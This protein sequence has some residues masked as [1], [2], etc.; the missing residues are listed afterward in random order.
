MLSEKIYDLINDQIN[1][2]MYSA[3]LYLD[4]SGY[5]GGRGLGGFAAWYRK[6][7]EE[8]MEHAFKFYDYLHDNG[9]KVELKA[10][11]K[12]D[13]VLK[14]DKEVLQMALEHEKYVT[15]LINNIYEASATERD[16]R[17]KQ[18]LD[19][20]V[21]EQLEEEANA[22]ELISKYELYG[23]CAAGL[24]NLNKELGKRE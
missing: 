16:F 2:E 3:Y 14:D 18:F 15:S 5:F 10:I 4:F 20:F 1:K 13:K 6:Q 11:A 22:E 23:G 24:Y 9:H 17:T 8:E 7:A 21:K 19:W 12:P